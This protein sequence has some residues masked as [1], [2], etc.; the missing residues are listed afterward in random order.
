MEIST[1]IHQWAEWTW[2]ARKQRAVTRE[3]VGELINLGL[4]ENRKR[5]ETLV[6]QLVHFWML[7]VSS[8]RTLSR[9]ILPETAIKSLQKKKKSTRQ[10]SEEKKKQQKKKTKKLTSIAFRWQW[11]QLSRD[12]YTFGS[13]YSNPSRS[14]WVLEPRRSHQTGLDFKK[15]SHC[16]VRGLWCVGRFPQWRDP[17]QSPLWSEEKLSWRTA[18]GGKREFFGRWEYSERREPWH[19]CCICW[20]DISRWSWEQSQEAVGKNNIKIGLEE[21]VRNEP[22]GAV[23]LGSFSSKHLLITG[24]VDPPSFLCLRLPSPHNTSPNY[25]AEA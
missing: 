5:F 7:C 20:G 4:E 18:R 2:V 14:I 19:I 3:L 21:G 6:L 13:N 16:F 24:Q 10:N 9:L 17:S 1:S 22:A 11:G 8:S 25:H 15:Q 12:T 23:P